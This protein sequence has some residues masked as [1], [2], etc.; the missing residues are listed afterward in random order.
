[1]PSGGNVSRQQ[2]KQKQNKAEAR[3]LLVVIIICSKTQLSKTKQIL[4]VVI[5]HQQG[6]HRTA[7]GDHRA[8]AANQL[9][10]KVVT[11]EEDHEW[12]D[13]VLR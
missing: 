3:L 6:G 2:R 9:Q 1:M 11:A 13:L 8:E 4:L 5:Q 10:W 12:I 7:E